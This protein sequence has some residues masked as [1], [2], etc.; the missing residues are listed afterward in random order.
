MNI[1]GAVAGRRLARHREHPTAPL[2]NTRE[3]NSP[4][5]LFL[6]ICFRTLLRVHP[7]DWT[8]RTLSSVDCFY[9]SSFSR[10]FPSS[11]CLLLFGYDFLDLMFHLSPTHP[12]ISFSCVACIL[13][14]I[15][16]LVT[17]LSTSYLRI[18]YFSHLLP[19]LFLDIVL[20]LPPLPSFSTRLTI[21][22]CWIHGVIPHHT[23]HTYL[24]IRIYP[25]EPDSLHF[26]TFYPTPLT[27]EILMCRSC[28]DIAYFC[29]IH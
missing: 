7:L 8:L 3:R 21:V 9:L 22:V 18:P 27:F 13:L 4:L 5:H 25:A 16:S 12:S 24:C 1:L 11:L 15:S 10:N 26:P 2:H 20:R 14:G 19:L 17:S 6:C 29:D 28:S 23:T